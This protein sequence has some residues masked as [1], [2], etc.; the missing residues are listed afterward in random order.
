MGFMPRWEANARER[1]I[2]S[3][4]ELFID[5][6]YDAATV[7]DIVGRAGLTKATFFRHFSDKREVLF[8]GQ[9]SHT[10]LMRDAILEAPASATPLEAVTAGLDALTVTFTPAQREYG[11][12][13][14]AVT[15]ASNELRERAALKRSDL[16]AAVAE[17][18]RTRDV[19]PL[20]AVVTAELAVLAIYTAFDTWCTPGCTS[21]YTELARAALLQ[22]HAAAAAIT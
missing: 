2:E 1:L 20:I 9:E 21:T 18:L 5:K 13:I 22:L 3:T 10:R 11:P 16:T 6:G 8:A 17:A 19:P 4:L 7:A 14:N 15:A 12:R